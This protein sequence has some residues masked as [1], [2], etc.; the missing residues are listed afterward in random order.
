MAG[1][2]TQ[3]RNTI[4]KSFQRLR[5]SED[6]ISR[7]GMVRVV[8][9]G[10]DSLLEAHYNHPIAHEHPEEENTLAYAIAHDGVIVESGRHNGIGSDDMPG[11]AQ[12]KAA[13]LLSGTTGWTA[14]ILSEMEG[15]Y[16]VDWE[17]NFLRSSA[18][19]I[20]NKFHTYFHKV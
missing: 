18:D 20:R 5:K 1:Y 10:M 4:T 2:S 3:N 6:A 8:K 11:E 9:A 15:W 12:S 16:R 7:E 13:S 14:V 17:W 19:E